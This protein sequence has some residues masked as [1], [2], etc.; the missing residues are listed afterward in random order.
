MRIILADDHPLFRAA[1][2]HAVTQVWESA[3]VVETNSATT[4]REALEDAGADGAEALLLDLHMEDSSGLSVLMDLRQDFPALPIA[5]VSGSE[6]PRV[7]AAARQLGAA[8]FI[9]K[10]SSLESLREALAA[11]K[12][13]DLWFPA[14]EGQEDEDLV[15]IAS[16]TPAQRRILGFVRRGLLNKQIAYE[17]GISEATVKAHVTAIF[18]KLGVG[19]R[20]QVVLLAAKLD[21]DQPATDP[22]TA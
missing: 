12:E 8:A 11:V 22:A 1:L 5:I 19:N 14:S 20:T 16:L 9:P 15:R 13:G 17:L 2:R 3:E 18:R 10:S 7:V 4:A 21:V 6:E